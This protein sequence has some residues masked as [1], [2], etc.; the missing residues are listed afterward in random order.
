MITTKTKT[1]A[2]SIALVLGAAQA[3]AFSFSAPVEPS[4]EKAAQEHMN[5]TV[6]P[7]V[8]AADNQATDEDLDRQLKAKEAAL[9]A[10]KERERAALEAKKRREQE[11]RQRA[12]AEKHRKAEKQ[13]Q[14]KLKRLRDKVK[15]VANGDLTKESNRKKLWSL[16]EQILKLDPDQSDHDTKFARGYTVVKLLKTGEKAIDD[17]ASRMKK[18][19]TPEESDAIVA[20]MPGAIDE[21]K[22]YL[23]ESKRYMT[24]AREQ[25]QL[26]AKINN[27]TRTYNDLLERQAEYRKDQDGKI[28]VGDVVETGGKIGK[29]T[30][31]VGGKVIEGTGNLLSKGVD[32]LKNACWFDCGSD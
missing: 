26:I 15:D 5:K 25:Q 21:A 16:N 13:R 2:L 23:E 31:E 20:D 30:L 18:G 1:L 29:K 27:Y 22:Y 28:T 19:I 14:A 7:T 6:E 10:Q 4:G 17:H 8:D 32:R 11:A 24:G 3:H 9:K 12:E